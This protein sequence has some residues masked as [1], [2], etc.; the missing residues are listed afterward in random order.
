MFGS[1]ELELA[2]IKSEPSR[3]VV[4]VASAASVLAPLGVLLGFANGTWLV[5]WRCSSRCWRRRREGHRRHPN[6]Q[7]PRQVRRPDRRHPAARWPVASAPAT[8]SCTSS[9]RSRS[10]ADAPTSEE[11]ARV[12]NETRLGRDL[13]RGARRDRASG[14]GARTSTWVAQAIAIN[15]ETGG[16]L[17]EVLDQVGDDDPRAQRDPASGE[18]AERRG[19]ALG[20]RAHLPSRSC[21]VRVPAR[22]C[23]RLL[24]RRSSSTCSASSR[25]SSR[26]CC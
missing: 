9:A 3:F 5:L 25:S 12:V 19:A 24:R 8:A 15:R 10:D 2:G 26:W 6:R 13:A 18:G 1:E 17:A 16:N 21:V 22:W 4:I 20:D 23:S 11:F 7:A 14:C